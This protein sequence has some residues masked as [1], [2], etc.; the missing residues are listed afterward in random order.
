M[1]KNDFIRELADMVIMSNEPQEPGHGFYLGNYWLT[2][3]T[4]YY[5]A[6]L[7][8]E[9]N[10]EDYGEG[11]WSLDLEAINKLNKGTSPS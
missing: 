6:K 3:K 11:N 9:V 7:I 8:Q 2:P 10:N 1:T 5:L 4:C